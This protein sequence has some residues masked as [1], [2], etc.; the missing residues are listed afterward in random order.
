MK[1]YSTRLEPE[2]KAARRWRLAAAA[3][4]WTLVCWAPALRPVAAADESPLCRLANLAHTTLL[5]VDHS[6]TLVSELEKALDDLVNK[7][8]NAFKA[9]EGDASC[10]TSSRLRELEE[11]FNQ[12]YAQK[13]RM[14]SVRA[15]AV[16][17]KVELETRYKTLKEQ[18]AEAGCPALEIPDAAQ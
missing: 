13:Q 9:C 17:R 14:A 11:A 12:A 18:A 6:V 5:A 2:A 10:R 15:E 4:A 3:V 8:R 16:Q 7:S 1:R